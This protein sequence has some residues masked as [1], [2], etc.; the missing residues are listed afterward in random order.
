VQGLQVRNVIQIQCPPSAGS[1][2]YNYKN[3]HSIVLRAVADADGQFIAVDIDDYGRT[4]DGGILK[5]SSFNK[6][7]TARGLNLPNHTDI[8]DLSE[9]LPFVSVGDE[10]YTL[11]INLMTSFSRKSV[12]HE[13]GFTTVVSLKL[14]EL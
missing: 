8:S 13:N 11:T 5:I 14:G 3:F 6:L 12:I 10:A 2:F 9:N 7:L 4:C 1:T